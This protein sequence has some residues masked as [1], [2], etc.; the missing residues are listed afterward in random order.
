[1]LSDT[2]WN[3]GNTLAT[4]DFNGDEY[5]DLAV[6]NACFLGVGWVQFYWGGPEFYTVPDFT[7]R[8]ESR[9]SA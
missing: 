7:I 1:M 9:Y 5:T 6:G 3:F 8:R 2:G 4:L